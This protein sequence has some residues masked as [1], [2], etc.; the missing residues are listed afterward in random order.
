MMK[1][2]KERVYTYVSNLLLIS[3]FCAAGFLVL[4][5]GI[6]FLKT[7]IQESLIGFVFTS[8]SDFIYSLLRGEPIAIINLGILV[9]MLTPFL[10]VVVA[11]F[12]FFGERDFKYAIVALGVMII[13]LFTILPSLI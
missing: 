5:L 2:E 8:F 6:L 4:G 9:M 7:N 1:E 10:R 3:S 11:V 12:S 13:L